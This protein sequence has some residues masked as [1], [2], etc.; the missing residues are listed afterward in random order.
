M[1]LLNSEIAHRLAA[2]VLPAVFLCGSCS[3]LSAMAGDEGFALSEA[4]YAAAEELDNLHLAELVKNA[5]V[6]PYWLD[7]GK[8]FWYTR[9]ENDGK[10]VVIVDVED[11]TWETAVV[12]DA[13]TPV[14]RLVDEPVTNPGLLHAPGN[15]L[16][17]FVRNHNLW[18][19]N[20]DDG[21][22]SALTTDGQRYAAYASGSDQNL[23]QR[24]EP[25]PDAISRPVGTYWSPDGQWLISRRLDEREVEPYPFLES[26]PA[27][28]G[29]RPR[30]QEARV[31]LLG[32]TNGYVTDNYIIDV[33]T[34]SRVEIQLPER[35]DLNGFAP[36]NEPLGW[37]RD[38]QKAY[39]YASSADARLGALLEVNMQTGKSRIVLEESAESSRVYLAP[40]GSPP[41]VRILV[42]EFIWYSERGNYGHLYL[43]NLKSGELKRQLTK[44]KGA[45]S[46]IL[47]VDAKRRSILV[48]KSRAED[49]LDP[50]Q[51][52]VY[53][54][55]LD[56]G[57][58]LL[59][60]PEIGHHDLD[61]SKV[62]PDGAHFV[63]SFSTISS[64]PQ[65]Q[66][67]SAWEPVKIADLEVADPSALFDLG[68]RPPMRVRV[69]AADG[70]T[71]LYAALYRAD[72][73]FESLGALPVIDL[74]YINSIA[75]VVPVGFMD[76]VNLP[77][78]TGVT[79]LGFHVVMVDGRGTPGR[80]RDFR[81]AGYPAF[82]DIQIEDHV[83]A[84]RELAN[85]FPDLDAGRVGIWGS[86]NGGAG[87]AR[88]VLRQPDFFKV[89]VAAAGSHD[90]M[91]LPPSGIK[92]FG[93]PEYEDGTAVRPSP[94]AVPDN[95]RP[96][97]NAELASK[98]EGHLL[99]AYGDMDNMA[100]PSATHRLA[101]ALI[102]AGKSFDLLHMPNR[103]HFLLY[104]P[105]FKQRLRHYFVE[106]LH[107]ID[108]PL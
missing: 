91:S 41:M 3:Y 20:L 94:G 10:S 25:D 50:Y 29:F 34:K 38:G 39:L 30:V 59:L 77:W 87:A 63:D 78:T 88:A 93:V 33:R 70:K 89:A 104:E 44:G 7:G 2:R 65:S 37:S 68:W 106:H 16:A 54:V 5:A 84:I 14:C 32:D 40:V 101:N 108:P 99:L 62:A 76:A 79:R 1:A 24:R 82:A 23:L 52:Y 69:K 107:G 4:D 35:M 36:G 72:V 28:G 80:S 66:L 86:S 81:E 6:Q 73:K 100:L 15:A 19:L 48:S 102:D 51:Q 45:V 46:S 53:R 85:R 95:Y 90:Y 49:G 43:Y 9:D 17:V 74:N 55:S 12:C 92:F 26:V 97:D 27:D 83:A 47:H 103:G 58:S 42:D 8:R 67:R 71:D 31:V 13:D 75:S 98:L 18:L 105:Y 21:S 22:E 96:F 60:T 61:A 64:P 11:G 57:N 56:G